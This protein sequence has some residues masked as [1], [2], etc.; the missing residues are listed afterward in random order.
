MLVLE[1]KIK[2]QMNMDIIANIKN[3]SVLDALRSQYT[4]LDNCHV[5]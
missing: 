2:Y 1:R 3:A 4:R 5:P